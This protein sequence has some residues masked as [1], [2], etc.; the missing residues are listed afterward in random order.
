[1]V[2]I[3]KGCKDEWHSSGDTGDHCRARA[4]LSLP[5]LRGLL[6]ESGRQLECDAG[7]SWLWKGR[8]AKLVDGSTF[9]MH[10][11][12]ENQEAFPQLHSQIPGVG[13][14][15]AR[16]GTIISLA[17]ACVLD[18]AIAPCQGKQTGENALLR[19]MLDTF[20]KGDVAVFD[21]HYCSYMMPAMFSLVGVQ[22]GVRLHQRRAID[23]RL[24][25]RLAKT[26]T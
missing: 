17:T 24:G 9:A 11:T 21:R 18:V 4:K 16:A 2:N 22:T 8:H 6:V 19:G 13:F 12:P 25:F 26:T 15:I 3:L 5:A 10:D 7:E 20:G 14:P 1:M 23:L